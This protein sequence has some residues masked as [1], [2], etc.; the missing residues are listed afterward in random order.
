MIRGI[1]FPI[2]SARLEVGGDALVRTGLRGHR[3]GA[4]AAGAVTLLTYGL[5]VNPPRWDFG[6]LMGIYIAVFFAIAPLV[7]ALW[8]RESIQPPI[9]LGGT[10]IVS[11]G[12]LLALWR[13]NPA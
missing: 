4:L 6:R 10:L 5:L 11:G 1:V 7:S 13:A 3:W 12:L 8:F 9:L 2:L